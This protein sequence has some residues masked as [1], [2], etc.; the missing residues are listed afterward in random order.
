MGG[1]PN[2][3]FVID[4]NKEAI[5]I[6][7]AKKLGIP[8]TAILDSNCDPDGIAFPIPGNDDAARAIALYCDLA[9]RAIIDGLGQNQI[10]AGV[11]TGAAVEVQDLSSHAEPAEATA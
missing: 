11:D 1:L 7:E 5:A 3:L 9:A 10:E 6:A 2:M 8:V 4:T